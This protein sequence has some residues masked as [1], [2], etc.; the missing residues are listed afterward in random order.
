MIRI[1]SRVANVDVPILEIG[2]HTFDFHDPGMALDK[3]RQLTGG[4]IAPVDPET[5]RKAVYGDLDIFAMSPMITQPTGTLRWWVM[6]VTHHNP[7]KVEL[8][9]DV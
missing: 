7:S 6:H 1:I 9:K 4:W 2:G 8:E 5:I 3:I